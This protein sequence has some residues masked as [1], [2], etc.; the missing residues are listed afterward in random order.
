MAGS[1]VAGAGEVAV[2]G[3]EPRSP[4]RALDLVAMILLI[5]AGVLVGLGYGYVAL[6]FT[7]VGAASVW[8]IVLSV[9]LMSVA[10]VTAIA[11]IRRYV[12]GR[13]GFWFPLIGCGAVVTLIAMLS[14]LSASLTPA[15]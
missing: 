11:G 1:P 3:A 2:V 4:L 12:A 13:L 6:V 10:V 5:A 9:L 7:P 15:V 14:L 8:W